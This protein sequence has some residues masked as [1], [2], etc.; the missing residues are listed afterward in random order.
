[1]T[2]YKLQ[3]ELLHKAGQAFNDFILTRDLVKSTVL[4]KLTDETASDYYKYQAAFTTMKPEHNLEFF[5]LAK[6]HS[7]LSLDTVHALFNAY[8]AGRLKNTAQLKDAFEAA[9]NLLKVFTDKNK[10]AMEKIFKNELATK[11]I[12]DVQHFKKFIML[13]KDSE[14]CFN[15][16]QLTHLCFTWIS[17]KNLEEVQDRFAIGE[18]VRNL[19]GYTSNIARMELNN[20]VI[21]NQS[22]AYMWEELYY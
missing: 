4:F 11:N 20:P 17:G 12:V 18:N 15:E 8:Q 2:D 1:M 22:W 7:S 5:T 9:S 13:A 16:K 3:L 21:T 10:T 19:H 6:T 14:S